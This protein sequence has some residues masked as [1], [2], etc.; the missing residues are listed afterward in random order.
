MVSDE[1]GSD[2]WQITIGVRTSGRGVSALL[3]L[4]SY[5]MSAK[6]QETHPQAHANHCLFHSNSPVIFIHVLAWHYEASIHD[7][8]GP[9]FW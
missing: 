5:H 8:V 1:A 7:E 6:L 9:G 3:K 4:A 2:C